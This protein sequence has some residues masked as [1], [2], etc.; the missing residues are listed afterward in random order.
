MSEIPFGDS[1]IDLV[2]NAGQNSAACS[3]IVSSKM[4]FVTKDLSCG[5]VTETVY[6]ACLDAESLYMNTEH[7]LRIKAINTFL[8]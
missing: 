5:L 2:K 8:T 3:A 4:Q 1:I 7:E 6:I